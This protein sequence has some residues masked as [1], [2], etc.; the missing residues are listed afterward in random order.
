MR[1]G[2]DT[3]VLIYAHLP[4]FAESERVRAYLRRA[5][6]DDG[7]RI[8]L[9]PLVLHEFVHVVTDPRRLEPPVTMPQALEVAG[10]YLDRSN[11]ECLAVDEGS[12][13][14]AFHL[15]DAH[16]LGRRRIA[17]TLLAATLLS[18]GV[19]T[20]VTCNPADFDLFGDLAVVDP[21]AADLGRQ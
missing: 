10:G 5:L 17:D 20:I 16:G 6:A 1:Y 12:V 13:R 14:L 18:H 19:Q 3:N 15:L 8:L 11:V 2:V 7:H 21:R 4:V 9:T